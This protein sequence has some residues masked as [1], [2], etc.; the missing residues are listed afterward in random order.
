MT[1]RQCVQALRAISLVEAGVFA[2]DVALLLNEELPVHLH[3]HAHVVQPREPLLAHFT[4]ERLLA[5]MNPP[6]LD[7]HIIRVEL[8]R[9]V[10]TLVSPILV[11]PVHVY[12]QR[13]VRLV[14]DGA[15]RALVSTLG[16]V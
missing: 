1:I 12:P 13:R 15:Q 7:E 4:H 16:R 14:G 3:V 10:F 5:R 6:M 11:V 8:A 2:G 9:A